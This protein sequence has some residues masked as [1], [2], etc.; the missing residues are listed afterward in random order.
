LTGVSVSNDGRSD[1]VGRNLVQQAIQRHQPELLWNAFEPNAR[2]MLD[3]CLRDYGF[4]DLPVADVVRELFQAQHHVPEPLIRRELMAK[5][6]ETFGNLFDCCR[7]LR[8]LLEATGR[9]QKYDE[10]VFC[11]W[12]RMRTGIVDQAMQRYL[13]QLNEV[14][15]QD[16]IKSLCALDHEIDLIDE[17]PRYGQEL[18]HDIV[19][20]PEM[21]ELYI[22][23]ES[24]RR[25]IQE[26]SNNLQRMLHVRDVLLRLRSLKDRISI[27]ERV[28]DDRGHD[29][30]L[31][32][33]RLEKREDSRQ[34]NPSLVRLASE[35]PE[36]FEQLIRFQRDI[37]ALTQDSWV[38]PRVSEI[39]KI[40]DAMPQVFGFGCKDRLVP[41]QSNDGSIQYQMRI[42][43][44]GV[45]HILLR[46][47]EMTN[48][49]TFVQAFLD[50]MQGYVH[51]R[52][53]ESRFWQQRMSIEE[54]W[55]HCQAGRCEGSISFRR[56]LNLENRGGEPSVL[57]LVAR[58]EANGNGQ[59]TRDSQG[60][61]IVPVYLATLFCRKGG[62]D[63]ELE[64]NRVQLIP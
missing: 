12:N 25:Y 20:D 51:G 62:Y 50:A 14:Y 35:R 7:N 47:P 23:D 4:G 64:S 16:F 36:E 57:T 9:F 33:F 11:G 48:R 63:T 49:T 37:L 59:P 30:F 10:P 60:R 1:S 45:S 38:I 44:E 5:C 41:I 31:K 53:L 18:V 43:P 29:F 34:Q 27:I 32:I 21:R 55:E 13:V 8:P 58:F 15:G 17:L 22:Q 3:M 40:M 39:W 54:Y 2:T 56:L 19:S 42:T 26:D 24:L 61:L 52:M 28:I 46:H 6:N